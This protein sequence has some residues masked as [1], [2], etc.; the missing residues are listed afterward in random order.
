MNVYNLKLPW[1]PSNNTYWRH[2]RG[3]H[4]ISS[5][6]IDDMRIIR[7]ERVAGGSLNIQIWEIGDDNLH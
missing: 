3:R 5:K 7:S 2:S 6:G 1:P 4:F